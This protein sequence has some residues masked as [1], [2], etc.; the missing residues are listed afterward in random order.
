MAQRGVCADYSTQHLPLSCDVQAVT[1]LIRL[2]EKL[3]AH[4]KELLA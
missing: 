4:A 2:L 1:L 3:H